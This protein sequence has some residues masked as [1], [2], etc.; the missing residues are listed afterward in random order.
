MTAEVEFSIHRPLLKSFHTQ[1]IIAKSIRHGKHFGNADFYSDV[2]HQDAEPVGGRFE[3][4]F[5]LAQK[6]ADELDEPVYMAQVSSTGGRARMVHP[7][8]KTYS[9]KE[10]AERTDKYFQNKKILGELR[11]RLEKAGVD[12]E[13]V[14]LHIF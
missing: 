9:P 4:I 13:F 2:L 6:M 3:R 11:Y 5:D 14:Q 8:E 7:H 10:Q 12:F 1:G